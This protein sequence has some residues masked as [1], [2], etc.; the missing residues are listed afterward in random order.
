MG[1]VGNILS[2]IISGA[3]ALVLS[4]LN[5]IWLIAYVVAVSTVRAARDRTIDASEQ[6]DIEHKAFRS[7]WGLLKKIPGLTVDDQ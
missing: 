5:S 1:I 4:L 3:L 6:R 7:Y 2:R